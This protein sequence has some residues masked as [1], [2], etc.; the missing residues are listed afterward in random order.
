M[1][2]NAGLMGIIGLLTG[3]FIGYLIPRKKKKDLIVRGEKWEE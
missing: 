3:I 1:I 2:N